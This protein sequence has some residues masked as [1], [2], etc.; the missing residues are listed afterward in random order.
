MSKQKEPKPA[1]TTPANLPM[2]VTGTFLTVVKSEH[3]LYQAIQIEVFQGIVVDIKI[4]S[5]AP[6]L[7]ASAVGIC[8]REIWDV[9]RSQTI[10]KVLY[11]AE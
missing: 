4:L 6:D 2:P 9:L 1:P 11:D 7:A 8:S 5:K 10:D 3:L